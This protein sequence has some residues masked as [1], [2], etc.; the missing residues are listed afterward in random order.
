MKTVS[1][2]VELRWTVRLPDEHLR[3]PAGEGLCDD[4]AIEAV[5]AFV[6]QMGNVCLRGED[7]PEIE[8]YTELHEEDFEVEEDER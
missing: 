5:L 4:P 3:N 6:P 2:I 7:G 8:V 1:G